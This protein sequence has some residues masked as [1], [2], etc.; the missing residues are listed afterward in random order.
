MDPGRNRIG[1]LGFGEEWGWLEWNELR[2]RPS[3]LPRLAFPRQTVEALL[4]DVL[5]LLFSTKRFGRFLLR[6]Q[7]IKTFHKWP[8]FGDIKRTAGL[9]LLRL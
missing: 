4:S 8:K 3:V 5:H 2:R 6:I 9:G 7:K 1:I